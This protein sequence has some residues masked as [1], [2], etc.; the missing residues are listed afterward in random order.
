MK[1]A[2]TND[3]MNDAILQF[4]RVRNLTLKYEQT[5]YKKQPLLLVHMDFQSVSMLSEVIVS[6]FCI[7]ASDK[8]LFMV[9][10]F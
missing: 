1:Q 8:Q 6:R 4:Y 2:I 7:F 9:V 3:A 5:M 10:L